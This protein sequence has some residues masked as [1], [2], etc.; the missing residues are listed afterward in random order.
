MVELTLLNE[1]ARV[2]R[3]RVLHVVGTTHE[4]TTFSFGKTDETGAFYLAEMLIEGPWTFDHATETFFG[5]I[6]DGAIL[7]RFISDPPQPEM[8][9]D[10]QF[11][12]NI[13]FGDAEETAR[14]PVTE[15][16]DEILHEIVTGVLPPF[17]DFF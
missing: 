1:F 8:E 11:S 14:Y 13:S 6:E 5:P 16:L 15:S 4:R 2:D 17:L 9:M 12:F 7:A 3:H 10:C